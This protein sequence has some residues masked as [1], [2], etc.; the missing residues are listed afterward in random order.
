VIESSPNYWAIRTAQ[1]T[2]DIILLLPLSIIGL[3]YLGRLL[4]ELPFALVLLAYEFMEMK[5]T[6]RA[7]KA[8]RRRRSLE[9]E[10]YP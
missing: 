1:I 7:L 5:K 4:L 9:Y 2:I 3:W 6:E 10:K 8:E